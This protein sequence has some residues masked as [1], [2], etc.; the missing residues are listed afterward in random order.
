MP[1]TDKSRTECVK[2]AGWSGR[3]LVLSAGNA[4]VT[5]QQLYAFARQAIEEFPDGVIRIEEY[6][7]RVTELSGDERAQPNLRFGVG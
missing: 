1:E 5:P 4:E 3:G 7:L 6:A 2:V